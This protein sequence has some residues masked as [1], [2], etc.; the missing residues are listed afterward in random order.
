MQS[1]HEAELDV[2]GLPMAARRVHIVPDLAVHSLLSIGQLCDAGCEVTLTATD[3]TIR[4][5]NSIALQGHRTPAT[6]LWHLAMPSDKEHAE[7]TNTQTNN[8][9]NEPTLTLAP[10]ANASI[11]TATPAELVAF[12]HASLFSPALSTVGLALLA[13]GF[14]PQLPGLTTTTLRKH[15]P[16]S[17]A[18]V[19]GHLDQSRQNQ[20]STQPTTIPDDEEVITPQDENEAFPKPHHRMAPAHISAISRS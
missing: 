19:K 5:N 13:K 18:M 1:T 9:S 12:A 6:G 20:R 2:P 17:T 8:K 14:I 7:S 10:Q 16:V 11:G 3:A 4:Y 15:P